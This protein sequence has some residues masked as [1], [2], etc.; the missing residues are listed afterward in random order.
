[1]RI[2]EFCLI[3]LF[4]FFLA[5]C[6]ELAKQA[7]P[8]VHQPPAWQD[9]A[10]LLT[11]IQ[12]WNIKARVAVQTYPR[13]EGGSAN[14]QWRQYQKNYTLLLFGPLGVNSIKI[15]GQPGNVSLET[16]E[17]RKFSAFSP[18]LLLRQQTGW[19]L[20][21]S[22]LYYW[23]RGLPVPTLPSKKQW[24]AYH[25]LVRLDQT[26]WK[27][28]FLSYHT[29]KQVEVPVKILLENERIKVKIKIDQWQF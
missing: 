16:A 29:V 23:I 4:T 8:I 7:T 22:N 3:I 19:Q 11:K 18:E 13:N 5:G 6:A 1:M 12:I 9:R 20:P 24:D 28:S 27:V 25:H 26:G 15:S 17:G 10:N 14:L 21:I 2:F